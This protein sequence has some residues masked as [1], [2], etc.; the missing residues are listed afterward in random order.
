MSRYQATSLV[1]GLARYTLLAA[2][3]TAAVAPFYWMVITSVKPVQ[4]LYAG[5]MPLWVEAPTWKHYAELLETYMFPRWFWN[6]IVVAVVSTAV[7]L[8]LGSLAAYGVTRTGTA[9]VRQL[10][11]VVLVT[12]LVPR[13]MLMIPLYQLLAALR[14]LD[15]QAGLVLAYLTFTVPFSVWLLIGFFQGIPRE[16]D[17]AALI[18]GCSRMQALVRV[19]LPLARPGLVAVTVYTFS[20]AWNEFLYPLVI[21]QSDAQKP[22]TV[23]IAALQQ[24]DVFAW[25]PLMAAGTLAAIPIVTFYALIHRQIVAGVTAGAVK[26]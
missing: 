5:K 13:A 7:S 17:E 1:Y 26:G 25:G 4:E 11:R 21:I 8:V 15:S 20:L 14:L 24:G 3:A 2:F 9:L 18:D 22:L 6:T 19:V 16:L 23:G 12:Y 10:T